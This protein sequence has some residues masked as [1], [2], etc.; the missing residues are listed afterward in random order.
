M[1]QLN[2]DFLHKVA[3]EL[4]TPLT[5]ISGYAQLTGMQL[6]AG[7]IADEAPANL[8]TIQQEA[9]RLANMVTRLMEYSYGR[10]SEL[11]FGPVKAEELLESVGAIAVPMCVKNNNTVQVLPGSRGQV[12]GNFEMLVQIFINLVVNASKNTRNGRITIS[13]EDG[14][15][16]GIVLFRVADTGGGIDPALL[17]RIFEQGVSGTGG[18][19][20]GLT[21]CREAVEAHGGRIWVE[22]TGPGGTTMAFTVLKE[23]KEQ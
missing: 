22:R 23:A 13:A 4:K 9:Q 7:R 10:K 2:M 1:N 17:P 14:G 5:V 8:K 18:S 16:Q 21:I 19:G 11:S 15:P 12:H 20:L 6:A 3:H